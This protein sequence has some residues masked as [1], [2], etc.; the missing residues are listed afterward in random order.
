MGVVRSPFEPT[1]TR[2]LTRSGDLSLM[3]PSEAALLGGGKIM[4]TLLKAKYAERTLLT[5][6]RSGWYEETTKVL[7]RT[8]IRPSA[9]R[10][11]IIVCLDTSGSMMGARE[12]IAKA[13]TLECLRQAHKEKRACY[14]YAFSGPG[15]CQEMEL[16]VTPKSMEKLLLFLTMSFNGGTDVDEPLW[17]SLRRLR[18]VGWSDADML[19]VTDGEIAPPNPDLVVSLNS[20][21][22]ELDLKVHGLLVGDAG[23]PEVMKSICSVVHKFEAWDK[24]TP[25]RSWS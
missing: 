23:D 6:E 2:G 5:Y 25:K 9:T 15:D 14:V 24:V 12:T 17:R 4:K 22:E 16:S 21:K 10:G 8:E 7:E 18:E 19:L 11:P 13:L 3:M 20:A 1:E